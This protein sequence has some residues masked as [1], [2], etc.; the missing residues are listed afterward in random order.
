MFNKFRLQ[1]T[2]FKN[3]LDFFDWDN[4]EQ[5]DPTVVAE[6]WGNFRNL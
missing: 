4:K 6:N 3:L 2:N 1:E 5:T